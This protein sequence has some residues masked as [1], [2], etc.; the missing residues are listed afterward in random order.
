MAK[1]R[2]HRPTVPA[3]VNHITAT[4]RMSAK[5]ITANGGGPIS[6]NVPTARARQAEKKRQAKGKREQAAPPRPPYRTP[7]YPA[8]MMWLIEMPSLPADL[9]DYLRD[10][11]QPPPGREDEVARIIEAAKAAIK[12]ARPKG[13]PNTRPFVQ[14]AGR[15]LLQPTAYGKH[16]NGNV[17]V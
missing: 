11:T 4:A 16:H 1:K 15:L 2:H 12:K 13:T 14:A 17:M 7:K 8:G 3:S 6:A 9:A 10:H 5:K